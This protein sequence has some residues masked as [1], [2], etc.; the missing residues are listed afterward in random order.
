MMTIECIED[1]TAVRPYIGY[2]QKQLDIQPYA[3]LSVGE[4]ECR[5]HK[6]VKVLDQP[7][8]SRRDSRPM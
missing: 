5:L 3:M 8:V 7:W 2:I 1:S 6:D 4:L